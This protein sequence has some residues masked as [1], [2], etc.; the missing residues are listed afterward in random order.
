MEV[1]FDISGKIAVITGAGGI[2]CGV[3]AREF[4]KKGAHVA[5][6]DLFPE[7]AQ[8]VADEIAASGGD[9][10]AVKANVLD[11]ASLEE[12]RDAVLER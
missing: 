10:L 7:K 4:A 12:A 1:S 5:L 2:I 8:A 9:A 6:L 3:M 11:R